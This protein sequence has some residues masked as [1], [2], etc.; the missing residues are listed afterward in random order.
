MS[1]VDSSAGR[2]RWFE[3]AI[4]LAPVALAFTGAIG[5]AVGPAACAVNLAI[6]RTRFRPLTRMS[7]ALIVGGIS[8]L[9]WAGLVVLMR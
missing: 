3:Y 1:A 9:G 2:L 7:I 4:A 6:M 5:L 8:F